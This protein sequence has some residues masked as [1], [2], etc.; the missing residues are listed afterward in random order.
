MHDRSA[1][2]DSAAFDEES[3]HAWRILTSILFYIQISRGDFHP[4]ADLLTDDVAILFRQ[5]YEFGANR[6]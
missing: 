6:G 3:S 4:M 1:A 5:H 2:P